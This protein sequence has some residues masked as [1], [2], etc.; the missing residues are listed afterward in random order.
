MLW[1]KLINWT[2]PLKVIEVSHGAQYNLIPLQ[3]FDQNA[4]EWGEI[5]PIIPLG[6]HI[7]NGITRPFSTTETYSAKIKA[8]TIWVLLSA[9]HIFL[10]FLTINA[11]L[12]SPWKQCSFGCKLTQKSNYCEYFL[13]NCGFDYSLINTLKLSKGTLSES[14]HISSKK[15]KNE[16]QTVK[17]RLL[18]LSSMQSEYSIK[19]LAR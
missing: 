3:N 1:V 17:V 9:G 15:L 2:D 14:L 18:E 11:K 12:Q 8:C 6:F 19:V 4:N 13:T 16:E 10:F 7:S 5:S